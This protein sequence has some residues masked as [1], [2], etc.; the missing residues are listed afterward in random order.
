MLAK[1]NKHHYKITI[2]KMG[3]LLI[4]NY[5]ASQKNEN[6]ELLPQKK[7]PLVVE[8]STNGTV[9]GIIS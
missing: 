1:F 2:I 9:K 7:Q 3:I 8:S 4:N 5:I 6:N